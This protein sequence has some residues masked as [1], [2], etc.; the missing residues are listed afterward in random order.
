[1]SCGSEL[2]YAQHIERLRSSEPG[3]AVALADFRSLE[4]VLD[5]L[6]VRG[7]PFTNLDLVTQ[8][9][10]SHDLLIE[11]PEKRYLVFGMS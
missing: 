2:D 4:Q 6:R 3:L 11:L 9:E 7:L 10:Y 8:D 5:W 1:M